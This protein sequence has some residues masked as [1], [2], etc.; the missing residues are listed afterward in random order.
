[1]RVELES[2]RMM[3]ALEGIKKNTDELVNFS[4]QQVRMEERQ[5]AHGDALERAF[6]AIKDCHTGSDT[7]MAKIEDEMPTLVLA[8]KAVFCCIAWL[9]M[10]T[11][12][13]AW[14]LIF[15]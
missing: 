13:M 5:I 4:R 2:S 6:A 15:K 8:R 1:M 9:V 10:M 7:R 14:A 3:E 12:T 11:G